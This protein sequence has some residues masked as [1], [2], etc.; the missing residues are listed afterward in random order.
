M[1][2]I[3]NI[4]YRLK[5]NPDFIIPKTKRYLKKKVYMN[6]KGRLLEKSPLK[7]TNQ[8][9]LKELKTS[10]KINQ[11]I[12]PINPFNQIKDKEV[13]I[14]ADKIL[15][16]EYYFLGK[17]YKFKKLEWNKDFISG[18]TWEKKHFSR[19][20]YENLLDGS[21]AKIPWE[22]SRFHHF[23]KLG[24]AYQQTKDQKYYQEFESQL[25]DWI[26]QNPYQIGINWIVPME[27]SIRIIN[28][29]H[30]YYLFQDLISLK[31]KEELLKQIYLHGKHIQ[32][33]LEWSPENE[34]HYLSD[35]LGLFYIGLF[36][37]KTLK[38]Q[39]WVKFA[40]QELEKEI[41]H[42][43]SQDGVHFE[44]SLNYHRLATEIFTLAYLIGKKNKIEFSK[45]YLNRLGKMFNFIMYYTSPTGQA[46]QIGDTDNGRILDIWNPNIND[47]RDLLSIGSVIFNNPELKS[48]SIWHNKL[49]LLIHKSDYSKIKTK[50]TILQPKQFTDFYIL[51]NKDIFILIHCGS[52]GRNNL[53]GH[54][55]NDQLSFILSAN[56]D[57]IIDTGTGVYTGNI[58]LRHKLRSTSSHNTLVVNNLEQNKIQVIK[59]FIMDHRTFSKCLKFEVTDKNWIFEG[60][61][62]G[63]YPIIVK[64]RIEYN[65][66]TKEFKITDTTT[67]EANLKLNLHLNPNLKITTKDNKIK[68]N[69]L[70]IQP[71][72]YKIIQGIYSEGYG[73]IDKTNVVSIEKKGT[74]LVT[75]FKII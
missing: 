61:H 24:L 31:L 63:Y 20:N 54:G 1:A 39:H 29:I 70:E 62:R 27:C 46:P 59:P 41:R 47:H 22:L 49:E 50:K 11:I 67:K 71:E 21:D 73:H 5:K 7:L 45:D 37:N 48:H 60:V 36:F 75:L 10:F 42:Q 14:E 4:L 40:K 69:K 66:K 25:L 65:V 32:E 9:L 23:I 38:G 15:N 16:K 8:E 43:V 19:L 33:N 44:A 51:R 12:N 35:I 74:E 13:I 3:K 34:N 68:L 2:Q 6:I 26:K 30:T 72:N 55:H 58:K 64:R 28:W 52:I 57:Y 56:Q 53:G 17:H 18:R